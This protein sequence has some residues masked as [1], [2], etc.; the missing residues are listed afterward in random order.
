[1]DGDENAVLARFNF[2]S[3]FFFFLFRCRFGGSGLLALASYVDFLG[4][5]GLREEFV[6]VFNVHEGPRKVVAFLDG[7]NPRMFCGESCGPM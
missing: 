7:L 1:M 2:L 5:F 4:F 6:D 3:F